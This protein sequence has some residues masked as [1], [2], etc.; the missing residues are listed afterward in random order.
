MLLDDIDDFFIDPKCL[1]SIPV[2]FSYRLSGTQNKCGTLSSVDHP[3]FTS[4]RKHLS[5]AHITMQ[6]GW[7]N[8]DVVR[9][10]F[11]LNGF[12]FDVGDRFLSAGAMFTQ[13]KFG[14]SIG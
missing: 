9:K 10:P 5:H 7:A 14:S 8:G 6:L 3:S 13:L 12:R 4:L 11:N 2:A 1:T